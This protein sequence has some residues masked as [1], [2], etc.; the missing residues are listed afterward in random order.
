[1]SQVQLA[2][3]AASIGLAADLGLGQPVEHVLRSC[4]I[5][6]RFADE[7]GATTEQR[8]ATYWVAML[9]L[10]GCTAVSF[11]MSSVFGD[12]IAFRSGMFDIG[13]STFDQLRY[14]MRHA[15]G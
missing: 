14:L 13:A 2:E 10:P 8:D 1:M 15:G 12:D 5:A 3:V 6:T 7:L 11:E 4:V 9:M